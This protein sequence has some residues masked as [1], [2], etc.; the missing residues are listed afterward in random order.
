M[1]SCEGISR[2]NIVVA[3]EAESGGVSLTGYMSRSLLTDF[4]NPNTSMA[5]GELVGCVNFGVT[6]K[7]KESRVSS[8]EESGRS[9]LTRVTKLRSHASMVEN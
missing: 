4:T 6:S 1:T 9:R 3:S 8:A 2:V 5:R 7:A